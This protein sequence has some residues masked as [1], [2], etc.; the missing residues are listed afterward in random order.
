MASGL[1]LLFGGA[2][3]MTILNIYGIIRLFIMLL[4]IRWSYFDVRSFPLL[5]YW[6]AYLLGGKVWPLPACT[7][8]VMEVNIVIVYVV[9][10][11]STLMDAY[12]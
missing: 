1:Q 5:G 6:K 12:L 3:P 8:T 11:S 2:L 4:G 7:V 10:I 9:N